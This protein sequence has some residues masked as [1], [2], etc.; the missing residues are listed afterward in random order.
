M[1]TKLNKLIKKGDKSGGGKKN[2]FLITESFFLTPFTAIHSYK[3]QVF[4]PEC[5]IMYLRVFN[6]LWRAKRMDYILAMIWKN[7]VSNARFLRTIPGK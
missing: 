1:C 6:F 4:T 2:Y 7:Q 5:I 3:F